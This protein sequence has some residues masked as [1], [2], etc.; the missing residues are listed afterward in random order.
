L[1]SHKEKEILDELWHLTREFNLSKVFEAYLAAL[2]RIVNC[3]PSQS[4]LV[5]RLEDTSFLLFHDMRASI[6]VREGL[7]CWSQ[8]HRRLGPCFMLNSA[9]LKGISVEQVLLSGH[10][11]FVRRKHSLSVLDYLV[12]D[13][14]VHINFLSG[15]L[16][17]V[18][19]RAIVLKSD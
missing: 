10:L 16:Q 2:E 14:L 1:F 11:L 3:V 9:S 17:I 6:E 12:S 18:V 8:Q 15:F 19:I 5:T 13:L 7:L 4:K